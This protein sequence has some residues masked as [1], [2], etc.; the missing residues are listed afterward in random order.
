MVIRIHMIQ[1]HSPA[2]LNRSE[3][4]EPKGSFFGGVW[5]SRISSQCLKRSIRMSDQF[6]GLRGG[7]RTRQLGKLITES[8]GPD[9]QSR[10]G[11]ILSMC[12]FPSPEEKEAAKKT[13]KAAE[14][15]EGDGGRSKSL[16]F[17]THEAVQEMAALLRDG[18]DRSDTD[19]TTEFCKLLASRTASPDMALCGRMLEPAKSARSIWKKLGLG[20]SVEAALQAAHA[21]ST[22]EAHPETDWYVAVDDVPGD[23]AGAGFLGETFFVS[24]CFYKYYSI[25][26]E[27]LVRNLGGFPD[28]K[29]TLAART[30][31]AFLRAAAMVNPSSKQNSFAAHNP[32]DGMLI[33]I[34]RASLNY[35][36]AF[37]RPVPLDDRDIVGRSIA[38]L[39]RYV[40][41]L[42]VGYGRPAKRFWF[43]PNLRY[44]LVG[45]G[46]GGDHLADGDFRSLDEMVSAV[47][48]TIAEC[49]Q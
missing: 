23:D 16:V 37:V 21:M 34:D 45:E 5:R 32:P 14:K 36:N 3:G 28:G 31:D 12:G 29:N 7:V 33:E 38:K 24:A 39:G 48:A 26:W 41:D 6:A 13:K 42:D 11:N 4:G 47:T 15:D 46:E 25:D 43:S 49:V 27:T 10:V 40:Q 17:T 9:A 22:H 20:T 1:N 2:N 8:A 18:D 19:L 35:A 30:V 44:R